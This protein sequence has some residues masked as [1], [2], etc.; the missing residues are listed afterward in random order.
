MCQCIPSVKCIHFSEMIRHDMTSIEKIAY[1]EAK[2][3]KIWYVFRN[4]EEIHN[5]NCLSVYLDSMEKVVFYH[6]K[7]CSFLI[8]TAVNT[9]DI[10]LFIRKSN[11]RIRKMIQLFYSGT[12][13][14]KILVRLQRSDRH[15]NSVG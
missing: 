10:E 12:K 7:N 9:R 2:R 14:Q 5:L 8:G 1:R 13:E 15:R 6:L 11:L 4:L 3:W